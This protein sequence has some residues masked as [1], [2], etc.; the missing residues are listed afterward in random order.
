[1]DGLAGAPYTGPMRLSSFGQ[2]PVVDAEIL[3][4]RDIASV[5]RALEGGP[6]IAYGQGRSYGDSPLGPRVL[7]SA[8]LN[9]FLGFDESTG[10]L[11]VQAGVSL[12]EILRV[13]VPR[14]WFLTVT[15]GTKFISVGGAIASD[16]HGKNHHAAGCFSACVD[17]LDLM[18]ASGEIRRCSLTEN[19][20]LF[21]ATCGGM[22]L[23][24][25]ILSARLRLKRIPSAFIEQTVYKC[26]NL[27]AVLERYEASH[28]E[29]YSVAWIDCITTGR[30]LGRSV[31]SVGRFAPEGPLLPHRPPRFTLPASPP[32]SL[33]KRA[34]VKAACAILYGKEFRRV[35]QRRVHYEPFFYPLDAIQHWNR[36]YGKAGFTQYQFVL[37]KEAGPKGLRRILAHI[38][39]SGMGSFLAVLKVTGEPNANLLSFP[40]KGYTLAVDFAHQRGLFELLDELDAMVG[41]FGGRVY[42]TKDCR[43]SEAAFKRG[44]P[45]WKEFEEER[46]KVGAI[47]RF[48][49]LQSQRLGLG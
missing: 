49:S 33:I 15:P 47:G 27:D 46:A 35:S 24:G 40:L 16:V 48:A 30:H 20:S 32:F 44:Y 1:M 11:D 14:G 41:D 5:R 19:A 10:A 2:Y 39:Q 9:K 13:F 22:G 45:R 36:A 8:P 18:L 4:A 3:H 25:I 6:L 34:G 31:L 28:A 21:H 29:P 7:L 12:D 43:L 17:H 37:P 42:L 38:A 26:P 23:T